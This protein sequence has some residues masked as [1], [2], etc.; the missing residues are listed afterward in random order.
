M[1]LGSEKTKGKICFKSWDIRQYF[2]KKLKA[3]AREPKVLR[4]PAVPR[5][6]GVPNVLCQ[7]R[8]GGVLKPL[9]GFSLEVLHC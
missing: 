9:R 4:E 6:P 7:Y 8:E 5:E 2:R 1:P 3:I